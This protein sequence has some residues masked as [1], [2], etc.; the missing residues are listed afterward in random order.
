MRKQTIL[1]I[2]GSG[3]CSVS[4]IK[5][6]ESLGFDIVVA[7]TAKEGHSTL[8]TSHPNLIIT[9]CLVVPDPLIWVEEIHRLG[10][11][12]QVI[13]ITNNLRFDSIMDWVSKGVFSVML[14]PL[15]HNRL[16]QLVL[17]ALEASSI[18]KQFQNT[19]KIKQ[20]AEEPPGGDYVMEFYRGLIGHHDEASLIKHVTISVKKMTQA[21]WVDVIFNQEDGTYPQL[22]ALDLTIP[23]DSNFPQIALKAKIPYNSKYYFQMSYKLKGDQKG[24]IKLYFSRQSSGNLGGESTPRNLE[25]MAEVTSLVSLALNS[26]KCYAKAVELASRDGL[27]NLY[28]RRLFNDILKQEFAKAHRYKLQLSL[29]TLDLDHFKMVNDTFGHPAG[30]L[31]LK[32]I[33]QSMI[34]V[35]RTTDTAARIGGEEFAIILPHTNLEQAT[36]L[37]QRL[38]DNIADKLF[39]HNGNTF[40]QTISQGIAGSEYFL[41]EN[42]EDMVYWADQALYLAKR[43]GRNTIR[44]ASEVP[45][46]PVMTEGRNIIC[47]A[48]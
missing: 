11:S 42:A 48:S 20:P 43:E 26:V 45:M 5:S 35:T 37:A 23:L 40:K 30:D 28:N 47:Q 15:E 25:K 41:V 3:D 2:D 32:A 9:D 4:T 13:A 46:N 16:K 19:T 29:I 38:N 14:H 22:S 8:S 7:T 34:A 39:S 6:L 21:Q 12:T 1:V 10:L 17:D 27:T 18:I 24:E 33:A 44:Q 36:I 31:V